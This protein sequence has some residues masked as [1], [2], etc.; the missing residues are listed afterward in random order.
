[1]D[2]LLG[3]RP[4]G[5]DRPTMRAVRLVLYLVIG[6]LLGAEFSLA[7]AGSV[8]YTTRGV[9]VT[10]E[11]GQTYLRGT[12][13]SEV[14]VS[15][16]AIVTSGSATVSGRVAEFTANNPLAVTAAAAAVTAVR[17]NPMGLV[18]TAVAGYLLTKGLEYLDGEFV[19]T[20][21]GSTTP[22][23][24]VW[25]IS[26]LTGTSATDVC[27]K[28]IAA[29]YPYT[30][31]DGQSVVACG[32][33][34][35]SGATCN[36]PQKYS[37]QSSCPYVEHWGITGTNECPSGTTANQSGSCSYPATKVP[38]TDSDWAAARTGY[39]TD[40][41]ILDLVKAGV[42]LPTD[43]AVFTP[44]SRDLPLGDPVVDPVDGKRY[45]ERARVTPSP[46]DPNVADVQ[47]VRQQVDSAGNSVVDPSTGTAVSPQKEEKDPC[48]LHPERMGC[49]EFGTPDDAGKLEEKQLGVSSVTPV[50]FAENASCPADVSLPRGATLSYDYP[51]RMATGLKPFI[52][53]IAWL[54]AGF[55][56]IGVVRND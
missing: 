14:S 21:A 56:V 50:T 22:L 44:E 41:A 11:G 32:S 33:A 30:A 1:M 12:A 43:K 17:A 31:G 24:A 27:G 4:P 40:P 35:V 16:G 2:R 29:K 39:W 13:P 51:C 52:L 5:L 49:S 38:A 48:D 55:L 3:R 10:R 45:Q 54:I 23:V 53:A 20:T 19:K 37:T 15:N 46:T 47:A 25:H 28:V 18:T 26:N 9:N 36:V 7:F 42:P 8:R 34:T 6:L